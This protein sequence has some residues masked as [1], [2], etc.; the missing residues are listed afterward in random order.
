MHVGWNFLTKSSASPKAFALLKGTILVAAT[1]A[2]L[3]AIP[4]RAIPLEVWGYIVLSGILH[5]GYILALTTAYETGDISY[6]YP[7]ARSAPAFVPVAAVVLL[8]EELSLRGAAGIGIVVAAVLVIQ[9]WG[10]GSATRRGF[11][12]YAR[13]KDSLWAYATLATVVA[14]SVVDKAGMVAFGRVAGLAASAKGPVYFL[15]QNALCYLLFW[16][17]VGASRSLTI[18]PVWKREWPQALLAA[19]IAIAS[20]SAILHVMQTEEVS[21]VT[22]LRQVSVLIAV[23][24]GWRVL[25]ERGGKVRLAA[26]VAMCFG[27]FLVATAER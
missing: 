12:S 18:R 20:Y 9:V 2:V 5:T 14:F 27:L 24:V 8:G 26:S 15:L 13:R 25:N 10:G 7:I 11:W 3:P 23:V 16:L 19:V 1:L 22:A 4:V 6:V 21:Y 17:Y